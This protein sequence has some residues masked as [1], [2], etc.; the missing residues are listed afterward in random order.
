MRAGDEATRFQQVYEKYL[1][2]RTAIMKIRM[3]AVLLLL[4]L[5]GGGAAPTGAALAAA[6]A[7]AEREHKAGEPEDAIDWKKERQFWSFRAPVAHARPV[8]KNQRWPTQ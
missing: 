6:D 1:A 2:Q 5:A 4:A 7:S 8:V 3:L